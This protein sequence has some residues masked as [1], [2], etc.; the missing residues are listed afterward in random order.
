MRY[1]IEVEP[2]DNDIE[3]AIRLRQVLKE[4]L[5]RHH[6]RCLSVSR[7]PEPLVGSRAAKNHSDAANGPPDGPASSVSGDNEA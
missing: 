6:L 4:I 5:R 2:I 7:A 1:I 3:D